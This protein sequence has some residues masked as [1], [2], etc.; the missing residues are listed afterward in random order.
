MA[1]KFDTSFDP[2]YG[3]GVSVAPDIQRITARNPS[4]FTF[5]G[6]NSYIVGNDTLAVIDPGP[7]DEA[8]LQ[9]LLDVIAG[10]PVSHILV[11]HTHRDHSPLAARL[12]ERTGAVVLAEGPHRPAR[13]L[14]IGETNALD[15]SADMA[16]APD[17]TLSD[18]EVVDGDGWSI[19]TVL[20][21][22][23]TANHAV[24]ALEGT[25]ILFSADHV[26]AWA[27]SIVAPP[28]GAMADYMAS[29]DRLIERGDRLLLPGHGGAVTA[30]RA[31]MRGLKTHRKMRERAI[32]ERVRAGDR[33]IVDMVKAI[34]SDTDPRLHGAAGLSVLA[35]LEDLVARSLVSTDG[36]PAITGIFVPAG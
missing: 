13:P 3:K 10:R 26:M 2:L 18:D 30:P 24:F 8:H 7:D 9:T 6:T 32:L 16:F 15:A 31:F 4:P 33:T 35:H 36:D 20:T 25:G 34:Y 1:L 17:I 14:H 29:L 19:R 11:S 5:H 28:D 12:K 21:P 23:H 27:T 22:G